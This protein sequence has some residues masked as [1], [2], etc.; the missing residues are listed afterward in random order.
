M[1]QREKDKPTDFVD[2]VRGVFGLDVITFKESSTPSDDDFS[3]TLSVGKYITDKL[4]VSVD[5]GIGPGDTKVLANYELTKSLSL[6]SE[7]G[8]T[9]GAGVGLNYKFDY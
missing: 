5:Q 9:A 7:I 3:V 2:K 8:A 6:E 4:Y 1:R